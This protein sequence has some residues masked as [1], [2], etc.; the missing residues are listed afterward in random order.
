MK[1]MTFDSKE[2]DARRRETI[3]LLT[4]SNA[5]DAFNNRD[6]D[7]RLEETLQGTNQTVIYRAHTIKIQKPFT[8]DFDEH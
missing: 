3:I 4:L 5:A 1:T 2:E 8:S 6:V 7:V